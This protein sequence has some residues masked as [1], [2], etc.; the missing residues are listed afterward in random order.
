VIE[1]MAYWSKEHKKGNVDVVL[2]PRPLLDAMRE[3]S[4][5]NELLSELPFRTIRMADRLLKTV[6]IDK[7]CI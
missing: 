5:S 6:C 2:V 3:S 1:E 7:F 4:W